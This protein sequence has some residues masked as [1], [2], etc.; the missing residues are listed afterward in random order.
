MIAE[1]KLAK[2]ELFPI[3]EPT[4]YMVGFTTTC[5][6]R[7]FFRQTAVQLADVEGKSE[8]QIIHL[9]ANELKHEINEQISILSAKSTLIG[10]TI[11]LL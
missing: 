11:N 6:G 7:E 3:D 4:C 10:K 2:Y 8:D 1:I 9:A 5:N